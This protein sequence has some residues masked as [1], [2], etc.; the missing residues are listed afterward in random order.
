MANHI[1]FPNETSVC[2]LG[3]GTWNMGEDPRRR[4]EEIKT[5]QR[6]LDLGLTA[7]DTAEMYGSGLSEKLVGEALLGGY[8]EKTFLIS[9]VLPSNASFRG[10]IDA[11]EK[12]LRRLKTDCI[13]LYLLHWRSRYPLVDTVAAMTRLQEEG[14]IKQWGVSNFDVDDM[15]ELFEAAEDG[16][17]CAAN[18][19][20][21]NLSRRGIEYDLIPWC[22]NHEIP[23][24]AYS[25]IEQGRILNNHALQAIADKHHK[26]TAQIALAWV[27]STP[28]ILAIPK[29][30]TVKHVDE[31]FESMSIELDEEDY[32]LLDRIFP[33]PTRKYPLEMI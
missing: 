32:T 10:T 28:N 14:K 29:A 26:T 15:E 27:L 22:E 7:I 30:S 17:Y 21:Y 31:N 9:K 1:I 5:L 3:Q 13:D 33:A 19:V 25:P 2:A 11:C 4:A 16:E 18:E 12:S 6:G 8:R 20:L 24:I 23:I